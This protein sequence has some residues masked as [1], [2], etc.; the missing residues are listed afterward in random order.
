MH[1]LA[2]K[3][4]T[5]TLV[6]IHVGMLCTCINESCLIQ[7]I[8]YLRMIACQEGI[9]VLFDLK[10]IQKIVKSGKFSITC[11]IIEK[12]MI[13]KCQKKLILIPYKSNLQLLKMLYLVS[14][15]TK[16]K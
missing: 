13:E 5:N 11:P 8:C 4:F 12:H 3:S 6:Y 1:L 9:D 7:R 15:R 16:R 14:F 10:N 2:G